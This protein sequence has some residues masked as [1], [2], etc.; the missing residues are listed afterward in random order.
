M[1]QI[2]ENPYFQYFFGMKGFSEKKPFDPSIYTHSRK[3]F[4]AE[5]LARINER[6]IDLAR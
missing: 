1:E 6:I 4:P 5:A 2:R 3:R